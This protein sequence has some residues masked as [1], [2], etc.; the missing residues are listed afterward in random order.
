VIGSLQETFLEKL[1]L[2]FNDLFLNNAKLREDPV[3]ASRML[4]LC[5]RIVEIADED[6]KDLPPVKAAKTV[7]ENNKLGPIIFCAP[8]LGRWSTVGGLGVMVDELSIGLAELGHDVYVISPYY[9]R[10]RKGETGYLARDPAGI[11]YT[12]NIKVSIGAG[13]TIG[14]HEGVVSGVKVIFLHNSEIF[15][16]PYND[17]TPAEI[18][19]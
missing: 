8:E 7:V 4:A 9:E 10:N 2:N 18:M 1:H 16:A 12:G 6:H 5:S 19:T 3:L 11:N 17:A 14:V 13:T 15:P